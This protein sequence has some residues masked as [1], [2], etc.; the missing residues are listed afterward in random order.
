MSYNEKIPIPYSGGHRDVFCDLDGSHSLMASS[1]NRRLA[2][3]RN[4]VILKIGETRW[5][6]VL[7]KWQSNTP[8]NYDVTVYLVAV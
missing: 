5:E 1:R 4:Y 6:R 2:R 7:P 8:A 3:R